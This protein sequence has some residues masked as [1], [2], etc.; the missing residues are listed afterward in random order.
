M[1]ETM[2]IYAV[3][4]FDDV[5]A[6]LEP[7]AFATI[8]ESTPEDVVALLKTAGNSAARQYDKYKEVKLISCMYDGQRRHLVLAEEAPADFRLPSGA[9]S[10]RLL[11]TEGEVMAAFWDWFGELGIRGPAVIAGWRTAQLWALLVNKAIRY[12]LPV[13]AHL[14]QDPMKRWASS[15]RLLDLANIYLQGVSPAVRLM[16]DLQDALDFWEVTVPNRLRYAYPSQAELRNAQDDQW[17]ELAVRVEMY[18]DGMKRALEDYTGERDER[19]GMEVL[20]LR[21]PAGAGIRGPQP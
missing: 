13:P 4:R 1:T 5:L 18:L 10:L 6:K 21:G 16:P 9:G 14:R 3:T 15:D 17:P 12:K 20:G 2:F 19:I 7:P 11:S 8:D